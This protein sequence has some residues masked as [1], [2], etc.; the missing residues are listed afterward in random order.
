[1]DG[2]ENITV[3]D[4]NQLPVNLNQVLNDSRCRNQFH[5]FFL[6]FNKRLRTLDNHDREMYVN[7]RIND[8]HQAMIQRPV[9]RLFRAA[10]SVWQNYGEQVK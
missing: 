9:V 10:I 2:V 5:V 1:M 3:P 6:H 7:E 8:N 4:I